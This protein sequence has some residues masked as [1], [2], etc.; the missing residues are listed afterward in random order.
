MNPIDLRSDTVT[1][2]TPAMRAAMAAAEVGDD[3]YGEDPTTNALQRR[4]AELLGKEAAI[5]LP[6][7]T[8]ANQVALRVLTRPGDEVVA[9]R[10]CHAAWHETGGSAANAGVQIVE[11][12]RGGVFDVDELE[13]AIKPRGLPVFPPTTLVQIENTHNRAG[14][15]VVPQAMVE[16]VC[17]RARELGLA[18]YLD[19]ARLWNAAIASGRPEAELAAP[20]DL[21]GVSFSKGLGAPG[22]SLLAGPR[23]LITACDR[24]RRMLGGAMRQNGI[25]A[26]A[27]LHALDQHRERLAEDHRNA[28]VLA[29]ALAGCPGV[30]LDLATVQTNI[31]VFRLA[32]GAPD[33]ASLVARARERGVLLVAFAARTVRAVTHL[34]VD[35]AQTARA[36]TVLGELLAR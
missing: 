1:R 8:M 18:S 31:V 5:W 9:A 3:Q 12:G 27:A 20:F 11:V 4:C 34:D 36:A 30:E 6:S 17:T 29:E 28:R 32:P 26:A 14:G 21:V 2:P 33:A 23:A 22:G 15:V 24:H 16:R 10:E 25:F 7:G 19:G 13:A 35:A